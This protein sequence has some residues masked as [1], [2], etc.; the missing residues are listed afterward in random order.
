MRRSWVVATPRS[1]ST[2]PVTLSKAKPSRNRSRKSSVTRRGSDCRLS[3]LQQPP[4]APASAS[5]WPSSMPRRGLP[6]RLDSRATKGEPVQVL[7][8]HLALLAHAPRPRR[9]EQCPSRRAPGRSHGTHGVRAPL[10]RPLLSVGLGRGERRELV[11]A[12][13]APDCSVAATSSSAQLLALTSCRGRR[14]CPAPERWLPVL[15]WRA[16]AEEAVSASMSCAS[17]DRVALEA[18]RTAEAAAKA[19]AVL[20]DALGLVGHDVGAPDIVALAAITCASITPGCSV[21]ADEQS[22]GSSATAAGT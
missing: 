7:A 6:C 20:D 19:L 21:L 14:R 18:A 11:S 9:R 8:E 12:S 2:S 15:A 1:I 4:P 17:S 22:G 5:N 3:T 13:R 10:Q 16:G